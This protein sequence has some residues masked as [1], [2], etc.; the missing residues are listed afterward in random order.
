MILRV[1]FCENLGSENSIFKPLFNDIGDF[2]TI[3]N[4]SWN[5]Y[6]Q[7]ILVKFF[8][9]VCNFVN[10]GSIKTGI[11]SCSEVPGQK[12]LIYLDQNSPEVSSTCWSWKIHHQMALRVMIW[13]FR[14]P[15]DVNLTQFDQFW[16]N[17]CQKGSEKIKSSLSEPFGGGFSNSSM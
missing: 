10:G 11:P 7:K 9:T 1:F 3:W 2:L 8:C 4:Y 13:F 5:I 15:F 17:S 12:C 16:S 6:E 14:T